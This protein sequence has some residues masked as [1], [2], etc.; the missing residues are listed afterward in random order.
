M[1]SFTS[2]AAFVIVTIS[3]TAAAP[4]P[5]NARQTSGSSGLQD[6]SSLF[7]EFDPANAIE[8]EISELKG[9]SPAVAEAE[10]SRQ[11]IA[12]E[13]SSAL[14]VAS[15]LPSLA[16]R[17][18]ARPDITTALVD[19]GN[20]VLRG[21][22]SVGGTGAA[23][24]TPTPSAVIKRDTTYTV[25]KIKTSIDICPAPPCIKYHIMV[26]V[27]TITVVSAAISASAVISL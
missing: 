3:L 16:A 25:Y 2:I 14:P 22:G 6:P 18:I 8:Q 9:M 24:A 12:S 20:V 27:T 13:V 26:P 17:Q 5:L 19:L 15:S 21:A 23:I 11:S 1:H 10:A 4:A 7:A